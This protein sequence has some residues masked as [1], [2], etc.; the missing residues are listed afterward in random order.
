[1][2][3]IRE[4]GTKA[5]TWNDYR[6]VGRVCSGLEDRFGLSKVAGRMTGRCLPEPSRADTEISARHGVLEPLRMT[7]ERK[8]RACAALATSEEHFTQLAKQHGLLISPRYAASGTITGYAF[9][10]S[11]ARRTQRS[12]L[13]QRRE[14]CP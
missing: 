6:K 4:D 13:V 5:S 2:N 9:A 10:D 3:L 1:V 14:A 8:V 11:T 12:G 7:L